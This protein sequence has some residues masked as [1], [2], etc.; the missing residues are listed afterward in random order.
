MKTIA[1]FLHSNS[2]DIAELLS[3]ALNKTKTELYLDSDYKL[4]TKENKH[5]NLLIKKRAKGV[6]FAYLSNIKSFYN[7][8]FNVNFHTLIPRADTE[9]IINIALE[10]LDKEQKYNIVDLGTGCGNIAITIASM[11][12][13]W[14][15]SATDIC[16]KALKVAKKNNTQNIT[17]IQSDW[18]DAIDN[19]TFDLIIANPP[20][21]K[22]KDPHLKNLNFEP[23]KALISGKDGLDAI[24]N[25]IKNAPSYLNKKGYILLEH[26]YNQ[27]QQVKKLL[28]NNF[29]NIKMFKDYNKNDRT[30]LAQ[31]K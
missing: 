7:L 6:P 17:F 15:V 2:C 23:Q 22:I 31:I 21:I 19:L 13:N 8:D 18:F 26:G 4:N 27:Q 11:R 20:Y 28:T 12:H 14:Q 9:I 3:L 16:N 30:I 10:L 24:K 29:Y 5:L 1:D 25:I